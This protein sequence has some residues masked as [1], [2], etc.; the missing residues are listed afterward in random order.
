MTEPQLNEESFRNDLTRVVLQ[1]VDVVSIQ[2]IADLLNEFAPSFNERIYTHH[3]RTYCE[4]QA[5]PPQHYAARWAAKEAF[6]K[7]LEVDNP[8]LPLRSVSIESRPSGPTLSL[9]P[10]AS[11]A[12][13]QALPSEQ[14][15]PEEIRHSVSLSHDRQADCA[16]ASVVVAEPVSHQPETDSKRQ[17]KL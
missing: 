16:F 8:N 12:L 2:R 10:V 4:S 1:G 13:W 11:E 3:E 15:G 17:T 6:L 9:K 5:Y 7:A 14:N